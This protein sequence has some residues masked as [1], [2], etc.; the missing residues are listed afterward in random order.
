MK[1]K[2]KQIV[3]LLEDLDEE[4]LK[5]IKKEIKLKLKEYEDDRYYLNI[6]STEDKSWTYDDN[7]E[8]DKWR[9]NQDE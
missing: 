5:V 9:D 4:E 8:Y 3:D 6:P 1:K 2:L 7:D